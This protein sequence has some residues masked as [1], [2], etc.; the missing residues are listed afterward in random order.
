MNSIYFDMFRMSLNSCIFTFR[1]PK[2][3][4]TI[5]FLMVFGVTASFRCSLDPY[6]LFDVRTISFNI[7]KAPINADFTV[8]ATLAVFK[9]KIK[10]CLCFKNYKGR[11]TLSDA[12]RGQIIEKA[13]HFCRDHL[14]PFKNIIDFFANDAGG[15]IGRWVIK[16][17]W[18]AGKKKL[19]NSLK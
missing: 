19:E 12:A 13:E 17:V 2:I 4:S 1:L 14:T 10:F 5:F 18:Y 3:I 11:V 9:P 15:I 7:R 6:H 8:V 16:N